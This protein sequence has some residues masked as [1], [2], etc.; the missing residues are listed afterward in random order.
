MRAVSTGL[1]KAWQAERLIAM[2]DQHNTSY[3]LGQIMGR[4]DEIRA[5]SVDTAAALR[6]LEDKVSKKLDEHDQRLRTVEV[7]VARDAKRHGAIYGAGA[8]GMV[9]AAVEALRHL[10]R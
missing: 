8:S 9:T 1:R 10:I 5:N 6:R 7:E 3:M 4:L 2:Q